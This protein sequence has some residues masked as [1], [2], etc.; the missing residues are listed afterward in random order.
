[1]LGVVLALNATL[2]GVFNWFG[3]V[4]VAVYLFVALGFGYFQ[5]TKPAA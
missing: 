1:M 5:F 4:I 2:T 3:W